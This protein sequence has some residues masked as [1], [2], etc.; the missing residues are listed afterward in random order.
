MAAQPLFLKSCSRPTWLSFVREHFPAL[1][2]DYDARFA[3]ADFADASYR[4]QM[5]AMLRRVCRK[6]GLAE[7]STDTLLT[8]DVGAAD[9]GSLPVPDTR[10]PP[11]AAR[12]RAADA[13]QI[14]LF[15]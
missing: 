4:R 14:P 9:R 13:A 7:R 6:H 12:F 10:K 3:R 2:D 5:A 15:A 11:R 1:L 8:R